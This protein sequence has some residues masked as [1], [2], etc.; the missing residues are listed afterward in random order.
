MTPEK[1]QQLIETK[2]KKSPVK[3]SYPDER[4][5]PLQALQTA[6]PV[7]IPDAASL[8]HYNT[9]ILNQ[10][11][12]PLC[13]AYALVGILH[14][15]YGLPPGSLSPRFLYWQ[16]KFIDGLPMGPNG[17]PM[18]GTTLR[19]VLQVAQKIGVCSEKLCPSLPDWGCPVFTPEMMADA[20]KHKIKAYARLQ[21]GTLEDIEN[22]IASG[23]MVI[24][25]SL[26]TYGDWADGWILGPSGDWGGG[27]AT[28]LMEYDRNLEFGQHKRF[29]GGTNSWG[30]AWGMDGFYQISES[31]AQWRDLDTGMPA[32][33]EAW[34]V[35]FDKP[36]IPR[37]PQP[38][39]TK[40]FD[41]APML[42]PVDDG[43]R[44]VVELRGLAE[45][46][47]VVVG[48]DE[49]TQSVTMENDSRKVTLR[50]GE[51]SYS[52]EYKS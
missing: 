15:Y 4:D 31:C 16:A 9:G 45:A 23:R 33:F 43:D 28:N 3:P 48:W 47:G 11:E 36:F 30:T 39:Q 6:E 24:N 1:W 12:S 50:I 22:A 19:A 42:M 10:E 32:L 38:A 34:A 29:A 35:E 20:S 41:V 8:K 46:L 17:F 51:K 27:H 14:A 44:T 2:F 52:V 5:W 26:V 25:G 37:I 40:T 13:A 7:Q 21:V 18:D 49:K